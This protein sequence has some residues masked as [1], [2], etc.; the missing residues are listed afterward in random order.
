[1]RISR[2]APDARSVAVAHSPTPSTVRMA[3]SSK[4]EQKN[5]LAACERWCSLKRIFATGTPSSLWIRLLIQ[6]LSASQAIIDSWNTR[7]DRGKVCSA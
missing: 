7:R 1:M 5:A 6:S 4:G 3:A 2:P